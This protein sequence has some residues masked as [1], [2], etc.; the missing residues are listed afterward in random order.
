MVL[1]DTAVLPLCPPFGGS[2]ADTFLLRDTR[3][4]APAT[5]ATITST[6]RMACSVVIGGA[7]HERIAVTP[8]PGAVTAHREH[9]GRQQ[10]HDEQGPQGLG[11]HRRP[12]PRCRVR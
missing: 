7:V 6:L 10:D 2:R 1:S 11:E 8:D 9:H 5:I 4:K 12:E 3:R